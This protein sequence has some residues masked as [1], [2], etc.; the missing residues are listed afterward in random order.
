[1]TEPARPYIGGQALLEGVMMRS[2]RSFAMVARRKSGALVARERPI[3]D[4]RKGVRA[5]PLL[6]GV[7]VL[8][9]SL[10]LGSEALKFSTRIYEADLEE[11]ERAEKA[12]GKL[13]EAAKKAVHTLGAA[14]RAASLA[15]A[16]LATT[17]DEREPD[18]EEVE[19]TGSAAGSGGHAL[20][21]SLDAVAAQKSGAPVSTSLDAPAA[22]SLDAPAAQERAARAGDGE[23]ASASS[24]A[25]EEKGK[26]ASFL[27]IAIMLVVLVAAPQA[28]ANGVSR[29]FHLDL[30]LRSFQ[31][32]L[33]TGGMKLAI[34]IGYM[35]VIRLIPDI[36]RVFQ[37]HG[38]EH[39]TISTYEAE[40]EL[41]V[42]NAR[43]KTTLHPRC[44]TT[45]LVMVA[46]VS[47]FIFSA[48]SPLLPRLG[49]GHRLL[50]NVVLFAMKLPFI[51]VLAGVTFEIQRVFARFCTTGPLRVLLWPGFLVQK[52]TTI[53]PD[54]A[55]LEVAIA[56]MRVALFREEGKAGEGVTETTFGSFDELV[57]SPGL[58]AS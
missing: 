20:A 55:Q 37:Y 56:A 43:S 32:Q 14:F 24:A 16:S 49:E 1:M 10:K 28:A 44:G 36:R 17:P 21:T 29:L 11:E 5:L 6:R 8:V 2:P 57:A 41:V 33:I 50:E 47:V 58:P 9:E 27:M 7:A 31:F 38:A 52:I 22:T 3:V 25:K 23:A 39:K 51:P 15:V 12:G 54:D 13:A 48:I 40:E 46:M 19:P 18:A 45:F 35:A 53:E 4:E 34:I 30:D 42:E 26:A